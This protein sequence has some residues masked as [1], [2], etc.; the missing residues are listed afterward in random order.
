VVVTGMLSSVTS[1]PV[2]HV[3]VK[4]WPV[5][6]NE[7]APA[8]QLVPVSPETVG[9][10]TPAATLIADA[11][12]TNEQDEGNSKMSNTAGQL[13]PLC[14]VVNESDPVA[15]FHH[16]YKPAP[17]TADPFVGSVQPDGVVDVTLPCTKQTSR[18]PVVGV[19]ADPSTTVPDA[20]LM[21]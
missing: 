6:L 2:V 5:L 3:Q 19:K 14:V 16:T 18:L 7:A 21:V 13:D 11:A 15:T 10:E 4:T 20:G 1:I 8:I 17:L 9:L 12:F